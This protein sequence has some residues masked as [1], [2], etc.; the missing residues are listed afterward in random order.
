MNRFIMDCTLARS[1][2]SRKYVLDLIL[3]LNLLQKNRVFADIYKDYVLYL[4][5]KLIKNFKLN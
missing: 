1:D 5:I 3:E 4:N 2:Q